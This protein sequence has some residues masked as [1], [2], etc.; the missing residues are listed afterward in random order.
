MLTDELYY[1]LQFKT[2]DLDGGIYVRM[3]HGD[4]S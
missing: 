2:K 1:G 4:P 3:V